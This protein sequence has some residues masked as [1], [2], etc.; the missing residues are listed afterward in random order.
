MAALATP[1]DYLGILRDLV[2]FPVTPEELGTPFD[3]LN[4]WDSVHLLKLVT[5]IERETQVRLPVTR[6]L[7]AR[8]LN[9]VFGMAVTG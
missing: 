1:D 9:E 8:S 7:E 4:G 3:Q 2:G 6:V 5:V